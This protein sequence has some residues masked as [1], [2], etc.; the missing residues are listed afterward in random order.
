MS[1]VSF[2]GVSD[3]ATLRF[4]S[5]WRHA[6][7]ILSDSGDAL[8]RALRCNTYGPPESAVIEELPTPEPG[9]GQ[10]RIDVHAA[11]I[12]F[13]DVLI[14]QD[15]YQVSAELPFTPG[16]ELAGIVS[17]RGPSVSDHQIGDAV[18]GATFV[19]AFAEQIVVAANS[20][21]RVPT[22]VDM[23]D[24][25]AFGVVYTTAYLALTSVAELRQGETL[26]V[27]GAAGGVGLAA[28]AIGRQLGA[29]VIA[30]ASS[31]EKL[32]V[33][34]TCGAEETID[35]STEDLKERIKALAP[36]GADVVLDP[37]GGRY[38]EAAYR[39]TR[40]RGR[41]VVVGFASGEIPR[42]PL[43][44]VLLK[45]ADLRGFDFR[46]FAINAPEAI[47]KGRE[48]LTALLAS[49]KLRPHISAVYPLDEAVQ[50]LAEVSERRATGKIV[51]EM[52]PR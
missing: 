43:N 19:G 24:A 41:Y 44:L 31:Q 18:C 45:G 25:A 6:D 49:G 16:S 15:Q 27:L 8:M 12:N 21:S 50:A 33:C 3:R 2:G 4:G 13:P 40:W 1:V 10:I 47:R 52:A 9:E 7:S 23:L 29:R 32:A 37:V 46:H 51:I 36:G 38:S 28:V 26:V 39:A 14:M 30:A 34:R 17:A 48:E 5:E 20:V 11:S 35:Y 22:G 42:I